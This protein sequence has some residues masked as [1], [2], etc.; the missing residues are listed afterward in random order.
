MQCGV[1]EAVEDCDDDGR[2]NRNSCEGVYKHSR[3]HD[4]G[5]NES[6]LLAIRTWKRVQNRMIQNQNDNQKHCIK[7]RLLPSID[8]VT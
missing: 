6:R 8:S 2:Q 5:M 1:G 4:E 7:E 3:R